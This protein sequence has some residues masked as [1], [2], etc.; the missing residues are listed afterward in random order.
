[1]TLS[2][3]QRITERIQAK[4]GDLPVEVDSGWERGPVDP[5]G[6]FFPAGLFFLVETTDRIY[7]PSPPGQPLQPLINRKFTETRV[8]KIVWGNAGFHP[9]KADKVLDVFSL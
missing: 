2:Q 5:G 9:D 7:E 1:V 8:R 3:L 4:F 6:I